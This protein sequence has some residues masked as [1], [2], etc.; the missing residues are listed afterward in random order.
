MVKK[1]FVMVF[2]CLFY[3][4]L[5]ICCDPVYPCEE[6]KISNVDPIAQHESIEIEITYPNIGGSIVIGWENVSLEIISGVDVVS[7]DGLTITGLSPGTA[8]IKICATT[9]LSDEAIAQGYEEKI[10]STMLEIV[11]YQ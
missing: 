8:E 6:L 11:V 7:V 3:I 2:V 4:C 9:I 1:K 5:L 10:Y